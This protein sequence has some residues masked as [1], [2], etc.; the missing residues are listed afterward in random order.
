LV[1]GEDRQAE[2]HRGVPKALRFGKEWDQKEAKSKK[3]SNQEALRP[4]MPVRDRDQG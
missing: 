4:R 3:T 1:S 2:S